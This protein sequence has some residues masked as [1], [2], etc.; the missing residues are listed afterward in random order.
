MTRGGP[1]IMRNKGVGRESFDLI[2]GLLSFVTTVTGC[3]RD[4]DYQR[5]SCTLSRSY[6]S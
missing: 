5:G 1:D 6:T 2:Q 3:P 4:E